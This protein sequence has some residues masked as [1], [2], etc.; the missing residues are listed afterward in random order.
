MTPFSGIA[1]VIGAITTGHIAGYVG[2]GTQRTG[3]KVSCKTTRSRLSTWPVQE[4]AK[5][6][7]F[8]NSS[9]KRL[10]AFFVSEQL[11]LKPSQAYSLKD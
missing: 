9:S 3:L 8:I 7:T 10:I 2:S 4:P 11:L 5:T 1:S 6:Q